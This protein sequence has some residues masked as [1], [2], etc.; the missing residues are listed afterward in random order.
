M[1]DAAASS[2]GFCESMILNII[3]KNIIDWNNKIFFELLVIT[4]DCESFPRLQ[5]GQSCF[6][7]VKRKVLT[8]AATYTWHR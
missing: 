2:N 5:S 4:V 3:L 7:S 8:F 6:T 1:S